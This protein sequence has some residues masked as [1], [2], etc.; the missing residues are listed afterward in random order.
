VAA[1]VVGV[2]QLRSLQIHVLPQQLA[3]LALLASTSEEASTR[4]ISFLI[5][6]SQHSRYI[7]RTIANSGSKLGSHA[8]L[9]SGT[10]AAPEGPAPKPASPGFDRDSHMPRSAPSIGEDM[11]E[12][13]G[14]E[15]KPGVLILFIVS[16]VRICLV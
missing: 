1:D 10:S 6:V 3:A 8:K 13:I 14:Q 5:K 11:Y 16:T 2:S 4:H 7:K 15:C 9:E 12:N